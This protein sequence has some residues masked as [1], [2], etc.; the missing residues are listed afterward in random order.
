MSA[1]IE[2]PTDNGFISRVRTVRV[3][4]NQRRVTIELLS[5]FSELTH[6][7]NEDDISSLA[8]AFK[9]YYED[10][11]KLRE[12][13][14]AHFRDCGTWFLSVSDGELRNLPLFVREALASA[15]TDA[16]CQ[17]E[18]I[19][20]NLLRQAIIE[21]TDDGKVDIQCPSSAIV[22]K[23]EQKKVRAWMEDAFRNAFGIEVKCAIHLSSDG[24]SQM[25]ALR[26]ELEAQQGAHV[27]QILEEEQKRAALAKET[28]EPKSG[29]WSGREGRDRQKDRDAG[30]P[31]T[32]GAMYPEPAPMP[33]KEIVDE[34][35]RACVIGRVFRHERRT[36]PSGR[37][38]VQFNLTD[39]TDSISAKLFAQQDHELASLEALE[40]GVWI[41][42]QG[43][44]Q[45][46]TYAKEI[47]FMVQGMR[48]E[49]GPSRKDEA[50]EKR[51]E[52]HAHTMMSAQ[53]G[54]VS[55]SDLVKRAAKWGHPA[56]A[57]TDHG[58]VQSFPEAYSAAKKNG[59]RLLLG[60]EAYVVDDGGLIV[61]RER[62]EPLT[63]ETT[64]VV[65][66]TETTGLNARE[67]TLIEIAAVKVRGGEIVD[68][69]A[70]LIDPGRPLSPKITDLTGIS[71]DMVAGQPTLE[72]VLPEFREFVEGTILV[73]HNAEFDVGFLNQCAERI[74][75]EPWT[76][77]V[78]DTL[79]LARAL[80]PGEKNYR[81]KTLT[82]KFGVE[83]VN[84]HRALADSEATARVFFKMIEA[85]ASRQLTDLADLNQLI[86]QVDIGRVRPFHATLLVRNRDG[87]RNLYRLVSIS[88]TEYLFRF[89]RIPK[90]VLAQYRE[91]LLI[92]TAC[93]QGELFESFIRGK[94]E[95][96]IEALCEFYDYLELQPPSHYEA[97]IREEIMPS[98]EHVRNIQRQIVEIGKRM[99]KPVV[100]T[101]DVHY[102]DENDRIYREIFLQSQK[103]D[104]HQPPMHL[105]TTDEMLS[106]FAFLGNDDAKAIVIENPKTVV[107]LCED[108]K[109]TP[110]ELHTPVI[111]GAEEEIRSMSYARATAIYGSPLPDIV[112][113]RLEKELNSIITNGFS[114]IYLIAHKLVT[115]SL[116]DGYLVGSRG[117]VGSSLVA[118]M[119]DI[120]EVNP[121][122]P[123]YVCPECKTS[124]FFLNG[125]Y[126]SGFD[127]PEKNCPSCNARMHKDGQDI[128]FE[129][130]LGFDGDK[131]P[132]IDLN[133]SGEYQ[134]RAHRYTEE[135]FGKDH[136]FRA[137]TISVVAEKTAYGYV[138]KYADEKGLILRNAE[139]D[140]LV[141]GC[142]GVKRTTG[143]HPGGQVVVPNN[144]SIYDFTPIQYPADDKGAE[145]YTTHFD[146]HSGLENC[147]LKLD[148]LGHDDPTVIR[149]LQDLTGVDPKSIPLDDPQVLAL[150]RGTESLGV[151]PEDIRSITGTY[152]IPEFGTRFV[153]QMLEDT[154]PTTFS[155]LVRISGLS[156][157]TDVWLNNA[158]S[159]IRA[160]TATLSE[161]I[162][163]R[164]DIMIYLIQKGL[165]P[166]RAFKIMEGIRKGKGVKDDD[167]SYMQE[168]QVPDWYI[169]SGKK[170]KYMF[171]KAHAAAYVLMAVRIAWFKVYHPLAFYATYFTVRADDFDVAV[172]TKGRDAIL[173]KIDEIE[174]KGNAALPKE[175]SFVTVL[176]VALEMVSRG[177]KFLPVDLYHS[178]ATKFLLDEEQNALIPPFV[179]ISGV[180]D[181]AAKNLHEAAQQG[182]FLSLED[183]QERSRA[184]RTIVDILVDLGCL[185]GLPETN[186]LSLF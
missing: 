11:C 87:L 42:V 113:K 78:I 156:H 125:E 175:K 7:A 179:A 93:R 23:L 26:S 12:A 149:M 27:Q 14:E 161:V 89:P 9:S 153:R 128:P 109:P 134:P 150:F 65:F 133:F 182:E 95:D 129:T 148:I 58:G 21:C 17:S 158:Q 29:G 144:V 97:L 59:I 76:E 66:D 145:T 38:L 84:H 146:Y 181:T 33:I 72:Q 124:E 45:F 55:A 6:S 186:Q 47:V 69:Y 71:N 140:R 25:E 120:T 83:L 152:A 155:E 131:V 104:T 103:L 122:P 164:D 3:N 185:E 16:Y 107:S 53:D 165:D 98:L 130:F 151:S 177:F 15:L 172:M 35:R 180:G 116:S 8:N 34:M 90:S 13:C 142:T 101:G 94:S 24:R 119:T 147:L 106:E 85:C 137:G 57:I 162:C 92:G 50:E 88:N 46:D 68:T 112:E 121:L 105:R 75:M 40:D 30:E 52:L 176:E 141:Q 10:F 136:V 96:E 64:Y 126:G 73:A 108:V 51:I 31:L 171:P 159:I 28:S 170:I 61:Y 163:A 60:L 67:D 62:T 154:R 135:L 174:A 139:I 63:D 43:Q 138:R 22:D 169:E 86:G 110:D 184:S 102:L 49:A 54:V 157:G 1:M 166:A 19:A 114:V 143:Q 37:T 36:L 2:T 168:H 74:G 118:T 100:A 160:G 91:G 77:P 81:L 117:S 4:P 44:V 20:G 99:N 79:A 70:K 56:I 48:P 115:K 80:Y 123:H 41:R 39:D 167:E 173:A 82:Q 127:L 178:H 18:P 32:I 111:D 183:L 5:A 132:D